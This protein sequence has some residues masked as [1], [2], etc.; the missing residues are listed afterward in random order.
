MKCVGNP[1]GLWLP[2]CL[3]EVG[4]QVPPF[5]PPQMVMARQ[6]EQLDRVGTSVIT[7]KRMG[8]TIGDELDDQQV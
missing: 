7:L 3:G 1:N 5:L 2:S 4:R 8:E 6:D